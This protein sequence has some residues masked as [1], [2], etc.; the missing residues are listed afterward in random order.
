MRESVRA[1]LCFYGDG[2]HKPAALF[3][4]VAG[5]HIHMLAPEALRAVVRVARALHA[6]AALL[7]DK[8]LFCSDKTHIPMRIR[9]G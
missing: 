4:A 6:R 1:T 7:A 3:G 9:Q 8:V 5:V 2:L